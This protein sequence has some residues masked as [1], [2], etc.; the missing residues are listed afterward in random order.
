[1]SG[2]ADL[3]LNAMNLN[4]HLRDALLLVETLMLTT[5]DPNVKAQCKRCIDNGIAALGDD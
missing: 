5:K 2:N 3:V 1:M 4:S